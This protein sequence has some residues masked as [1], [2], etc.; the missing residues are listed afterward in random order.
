MEID[1]EALEYIIGLFPVAYKSMVYFANFQHNLF[2]LEFTFGTTIIVHYVLPYVVVPQES[3][4][5]DG[6]DLF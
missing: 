1:R 3:P 6:W 5:R 2:L 4:M